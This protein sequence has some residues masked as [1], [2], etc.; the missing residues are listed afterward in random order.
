MSKSYLRNF[1]TENDY[2]RE[3]RDQEQLISGIEKSAEEL[4][5]TFIEGA[6]ETRDIVADSENAFPKEIQML[7]AVSYSFGHLGL[8][9]GVKKVLMEMAEAIEKEV[10]SIKKDPRLQ[11]DS[12]DEEEEYVISERIAFL[13][14]QLCIIGIIVKL[15]ELS[16]DEITPSVVMKEVEKMKEGKTSDAL[17]DLLKGT[18]ISYN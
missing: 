14:G 11:D 15:F 3:E 2:S 1:F 9:N 16:M 6:I 18:G 12:L 5:D 13:E 7:L 8:S 10:L 17:K 4:K